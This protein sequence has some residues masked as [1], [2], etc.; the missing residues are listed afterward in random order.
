MTNDDRNIILIGYRGTG[1]TSVGQELARRLSRPFH[2]AD[3]LV[4]ARAGRSIRAMVERE[5]W[6]FFRE[7]EKAA[8]HS[9]SA[10]RRCVVATGGGAVLDPENAQMLKSMGWIVLLTAEE[11]VLVRRMRIDPASREQRPSFS[12]TDSAETSE[13]DMIKETTE[14]LAQRMPIYRRLADLVIDST[15][16][17]PAEIVGEI[18]RHFSLEGEGKE[19]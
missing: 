3:V 9:L 10:I 15:S 1:K 14:I 11:E 7:R 16:A 4:E 18:L 17:S 5:G 19:T 2:D 12:G 6:A 13:R 8:I